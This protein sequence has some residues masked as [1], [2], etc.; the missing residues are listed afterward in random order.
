MDDPLA[1][2]EAECTER[3]AKPA[4]VIRAAGVAPSTYWRWRK[5]KFEP[6]PRTIRKLREAIGQVAPV[7]QD[8][9]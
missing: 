5:D 2:F 6:R 8:A 4:D 1:D 9:A 3:G 7:A